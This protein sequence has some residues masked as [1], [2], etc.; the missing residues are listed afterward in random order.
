MRNAQQ[1][2]KQHT[3]ARKGSNLGVLPVYPIEDGIEGAVTKAR[4]CPALFV[5]F[6]SLTEPLRAE[7]IGVAEG[8]VNALEGFG[9]GHEDLEGETSADAGIECSW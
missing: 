6:V 9:A 4:F 1:R 7:V 3:K 8:F 2:S 5:F